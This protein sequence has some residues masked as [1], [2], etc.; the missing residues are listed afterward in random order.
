MENIG[1]FLSIFCVSFLCLVASAQTKGEK[2]LTFIA[3]EQGAVDQLKTLL[4]SGANVNEIYEGVSLLNYACSGVRNMNNDIVKT[5]LSSPLINVKTI[6][7][8]EPGNDATWATTP[9]I[10]ACLVFSR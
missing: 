9:V 6:T 10:E 2:P 7:I 4:S 5:L 8:T 3:L 1:K